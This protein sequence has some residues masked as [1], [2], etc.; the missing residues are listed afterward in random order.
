MLVITLVIDKLDPLLCHV[1]R[2]RNECI[3]ITHMLNY[4]LLDTQAQRRAGVETQTDGKSDALVLE[5]TAVSDSS[6]S[7]ESPQTNV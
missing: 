6:K 2:L 5:N 7:P 4:G 3:K 1:L